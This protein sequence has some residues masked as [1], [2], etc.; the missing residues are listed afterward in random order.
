MAS[1]WFADNAH[2]PLEPSAGVNAYQAQTI[3]DLMTRG[4]P[5]NEIASAVGLPASFIQSLTGYNMNGPANAATEDTSGTTGTGATST[6]SDPIQFIRDWQAS[7]PFSQQSLADLKT[8]LQTQFNISPWSDPTYGLSGNE[9]NINGQKTKIYSEG[10]NS[11]YDPAGRSD[12]GGGGGAQSLAVYGQNAPTFAAQPYTPPKPFSY[13]GFT[14]PAAFTPPTANDVL[15]DP[16]FQFRLQEGQQALER[17]A[18]ARGTLLTGGTLKDLA[19]FS[20]GLASTE[21]GNAYDRS[22]NTWNANTSN[23]YN[24][25]N[26][27]RNNAFQNYTTNAGIGYDANALNNN[28]SLNAFNAN[29]GAQ[30]QTFNQQRSTSL[31]AYNQSQ[32]YLHNLFG[33][34]NAL[35]GYTGVPSAYVPS[36]LY[37]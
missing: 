35:Q 2:Q 36:Y 32:D 11:W 28:T 22:L 33:Y 37:S 23:A 10:G 13:P 7:H 31:D 4:I 29:L 27:D 16:G 6:T 1:D 21:Y 9:V 12:D 20:Q 8:A 34:T 26:T 25:Y 5:L 24:A 19:D 15:N 18:S 17:S 14:P 30:N 3:N